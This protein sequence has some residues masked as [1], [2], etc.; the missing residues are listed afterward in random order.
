MKETARGLLTLEEQP[1]TF[2]ILH[3]G[4]RCYARSLKQA[5][6][7]L[8][9][10]QS[11]VVIEQQPDVVQYRSIARTSLLDPAQQKRLKSRIYVVDY[12]IERR[13]EVSN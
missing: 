8:I 3:K 7:G 10:P 9:H 1:E 4:A 12:Y 5:F 2:T 6:H 11:N 13:E